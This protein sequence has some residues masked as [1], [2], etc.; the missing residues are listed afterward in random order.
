MRIV[1]RV[2]CVGTHFYPFMTR[3]SVMSVKNLMKY[4]IRKQDQINARR[5]EAKVKWM[6]T[7]TKVCVVCDN[8]FQTQDFDDLACSLDCYREARRCQK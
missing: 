3:K 2:K 8:K 5:T 6:R 7:K 1:S 4:E